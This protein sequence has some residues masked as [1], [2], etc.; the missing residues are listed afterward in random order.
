[1]GRYFFT[2]FIFILQRRMTATNSLIERYLITCLLALAAEA[3]V[4]GDEMLLWCCVERVEAMQRSSSA[5]SP[6]L[7]PGKDLPWCR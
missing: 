3:R 2:K 1:M 6:S 7:L 4:N 5:E